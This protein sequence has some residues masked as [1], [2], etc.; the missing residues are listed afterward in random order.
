MIVGLLLAAGGATRFGSQ[1][2]VAPY[3]GGPLV[4]HAAD[5]LASVT[6]RAIAVVGNE[7][8]AV[9]DALEGS[10]LTVVENVDWAEGLSSSLKQGVKAVPADADAVVV[11]LGDQ[12]ELDVEIVE[13]LIETW[14]AS[15][16]PIV[17]ARYRGTRAPPVL[18]AREMFREVLQLRGDYGAKRLMD[19]VPGRVG[20][21]DVDRAIPFDVDTPGDLRDR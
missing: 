8:P 10:E 2:L 4:R 7:A 5:R 12:P 3:R 18:I 16:L 21:V 19:V 9:R 17:T 13:A 1:K 20:Y 6:D 15:G 11:A 14:H